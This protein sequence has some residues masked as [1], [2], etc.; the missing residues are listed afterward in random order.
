MRT[1]SFDFFDVMVY[2]FK[3][4]VFCGGAYER[5]IIISY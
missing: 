2:K 4:D 3:Q 1:S 5:Q